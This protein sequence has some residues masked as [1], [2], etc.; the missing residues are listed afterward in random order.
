[1]FRV[2]FIQHRPVVIKLSC[3]KFPHCLRKKE[4]IL[5]TRDEEFG[6]K[7]SV[8]T[9]LVRLTLLVTSPPFTG[10]RPNPFVLSIFTNLLFVYKLPCSSNFFGS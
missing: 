6:A 8:Q 5:I 3:A 7:K 1:M 2:S 9:N 10:P 4:D